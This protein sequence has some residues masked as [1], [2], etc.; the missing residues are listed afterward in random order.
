MRRHSNHGDNP[1]PL[2]RWGRGN[3]P[4][5]YRWGR[6]FLLTKSPLPCLSR[7]KINLCRGMKI[8]RAP[9]RNY[10]ADGGPWCPSCSCWTECDGD[11]AAANVCVRCGRPGVIIK[12]PAWASRTRAKLRGV[13]LNAEAVHSEFE[14]MR[15]A[16]E[17][18]EEWK[19]Q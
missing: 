15:A 6:F 4:I 7:Q 19:P 18:A 10:G 5:C 3:A 9:V 13:Q 1:L 14:R 16:V 12:P 8:Q 11:A 17:A 2:L